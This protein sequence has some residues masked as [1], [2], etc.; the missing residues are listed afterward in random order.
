MFVEQLGLGR[1]YERTLWRLREAFD[2]REATDRRQSV[3]FIGMNSRNKFG[4]DTYRPGEQREEC[5]KGLAC[6]YILNKGSPPSKR[7]H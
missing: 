6:R 1:L 2:P 3:L 7:S 4:G 5:A